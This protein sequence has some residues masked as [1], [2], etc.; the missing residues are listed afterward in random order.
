MMGG[1]GPRIA[2]L[3]LLAAAMAVSPGSARIADPPARE[4]Q[5]VGRAGLLCVWAVNAS[6]VEVGR[7]CAGARNAPFQAELER[8]VSRLEDYTRRHSTEGAALMAEYRARQIVG[9]AQLCHPDTLE[10]YQQ[11][12]EGAAGALGALLGETDRL[13]ASS[14]PVEWGTCL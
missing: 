11:A 7:R 9:D 3:A 1:T 14:P 4:Q 5:V 12:S 2:A 6:L 8:S 10:L 13:L